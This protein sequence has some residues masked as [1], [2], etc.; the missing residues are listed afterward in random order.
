LANAKL[1]AVHGIAGPLGGMYDAPHGAIC[2]RL[3][4]FVME[5]NI[6]ALRTDISGGEALKRYKDIAVLLTGSRKASPEDGVKWVSDLCAEMEVLPLGEYGLTI[7]DI[8]DLVEKSLASSSMKG[9]PVELSRK[10][11]RNIIED[12]M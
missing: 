10:E 6:N 12:A 7:D 2:A 4:P 8:P 3:L 5:G 9:N 11:L 1:G